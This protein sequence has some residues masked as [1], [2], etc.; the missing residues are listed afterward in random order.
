MRKVIASVHTTLDGFISGPKG[1][2][3]W[4]WPQDEEA[5][6]EI[7]DLLEHFSN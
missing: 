5:E 2:L 6:N 3:D 1:E 4:L 7:S